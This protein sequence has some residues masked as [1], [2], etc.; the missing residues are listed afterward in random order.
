MV[1]FSDDFPSF[2]RLGDLNLASKTD[3]AEAMDVD[4]KKFHKHK[5]YFKNFK[6]NDIAVIEL[7]KDVTFSEHI[8]PAC[9]QQDG[10][11]QNPVVVVRLIFFHQI[12]FLL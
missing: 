6:D 12:S 1:A 2:V 8:R 10:R 4:V 5:D 9:L 7:A 3:G 11:F